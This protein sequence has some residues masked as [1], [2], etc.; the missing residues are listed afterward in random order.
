M[1]LK[2]N[3]IRKPNLTKHEQDDKTKAWIKT[4]TVKNIRNPKPKT[5]QPYIMTRSPSF[6][7]KCNFYL[8]AYC[9]SMMYPPGQGAY[10][11][12]GL[13]SL[14]CAAGCAVREGGLPGWAGAADDG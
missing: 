10:I 2:Y 13:A 8:N 7:V 14:L 11:V 5:K 4:L 12:L 1:K 9:F 3:Q 6:S